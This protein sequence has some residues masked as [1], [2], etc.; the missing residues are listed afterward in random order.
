LGQEQAV[1]RGKQVNANK[2]T[3]DT[4]PASR[5]DTELQE[6][7]DYYLEHGLL[8]FTAAFLRK[9]GYCCESGC[10]HCPYEYTRKEKES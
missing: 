5:H 2:S 9:R 3:E 7:Q 10:R 1:M 8:V 6:G 4:D